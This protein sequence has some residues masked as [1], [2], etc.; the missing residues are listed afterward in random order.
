MNASKPSSHVSA[1]TPPICERS[2]TSSNS[3]PTSPASRQNRNGRPSTDSGGS[4]GIGD[5][6]G[7]AGHILGIA[8]GVTLIGLAVL[9]PLALIALLTWLAHRAWVRAQ[10]GA[11][12]ATRNRR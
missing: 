9:G 10:R 4:W 1:A 6:F 5:A 8:A 7:D 12:C 11:P 3:A 2:W